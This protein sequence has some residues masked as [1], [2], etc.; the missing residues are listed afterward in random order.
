VP[1][2]DQSVSF[3]GER[4]RLRGY[5]AWPEGEGPFP[6]VVI[7]HEAFGLNDNIQ[8]ITCRF[9]NAGY[10][11]FAVDLFAGRN[12]AVCMARFV[13]GMLRGAP[14]RF[15]VGDLKAAL[16]V[17]AEQPSVEGD[18]IG[19][20]GFCMGGGLAVAWACTDD[21]LRAIAP[22]YGV[23]PRP[24]GAVSRSCPVV[25]SYPEKDFTARSGHKLDAELGRHGIPRDI[26]V[27]EGTRHSFFNDSGRTYDTTASEDAWHRTLAFFDEHLTP[28]RC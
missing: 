20:I 13:G 9:A 2:T 28:P 14:E 17:L 26:K 15:G 25:G 8:E 18:R 21:R 23:N 1:V 24:L 4:Q 7:I 22:F 12:R 10:A 11:A 5:L 27:Y 3:Q 16:S 6:G 19:A